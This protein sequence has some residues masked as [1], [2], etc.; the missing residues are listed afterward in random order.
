MNFIYGFL[1]TVLTV[2]YMHYKLRPT[3]WNLFFFV[4]ALTFGFFIGIEP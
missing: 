1:L 2:G 4:V 3:R